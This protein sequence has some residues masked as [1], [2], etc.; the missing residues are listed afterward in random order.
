M[1][2]HTSIR[3]L[4]E[5]NPTQLTQ[6][7]QPIHT[8]PPKP[9]TQTPTRNLYETHHTHVI[10]TTTHTTTASKSSCGCLGQACQCLGGTVGVLVIIA[11]IISNLCFFV[12]GLVFAIEEYSDI[13][14]CAK[15]YRG[16]SIAM[17]AIYFLAACQSNNA[18][19]KWSY[20]VS[21]DNTGAVLC[22][23]LWIVAIFP[24]LIAGLGNRDVLKHP[25][26]NCDLSG[27]DGLVQWTNWIVYYNWVLMGMLLFAGLVSCILG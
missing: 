7:S 21:G 13:P 10:D 12:S 18:K 6:L 22:V 15:T 16:W 9:P 5:G 11:L 17:V 26:E 20:I 2:E 19:K 24:G 25:A 4:P 3:V 1:T 14:D 27:I 8:Q 23:S